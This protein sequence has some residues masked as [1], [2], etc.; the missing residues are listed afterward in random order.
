[1]GLGFIPRDESHDADGRNMISDRCRADQ[2][3][4][5][6]V[7]MMIGASPVRLGCASHPAALTSELTEILTT[8]VAKDAQK[9]LAAPVAPG[10]LSWLNRDVSQ[11]FLAANRLGWPSR[12][13]FA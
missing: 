11:R 5:A 12:K 4:E 1:M 3:I 10:K 9:G 2:A 7:S 8:H 6:L 13:Y